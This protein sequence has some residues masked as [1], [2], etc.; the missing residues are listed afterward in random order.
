MRQSIVASLASSL[1]L[2]LSACAADPEAM[3]PEPEPMPD[4]P[5]APD[6]P[7]V[8]APTPAVGLAVASPQARVIRGNVTSID[9]NVMRSG[10]ATGVI[11]VSVEGLPTG[12]TAAGVTIA[13][14]MTTGSL[15]LSGDMSLALG[16]YAT[17]TVR[18]K[19]GA[20]EATQPLE[21]HLTDPS[22]ALDLTLGAG[23]MFS[24]NYA[25]KHD[26]I[27]RRVAM[28]PDGRILVAGEDQTGK[29]IFIARYL[30]DGAR[31]D[32]F[33]I[34][35]M[36]SVGD[37]VNAPTTLAL[38]PTA[39]GRILLVAKWNGATRVMAFTA[40]GATDTTYGTSGVLDLSKVGIGSFLASTAVIQADGTVLLA[41]MGVGTFD[42]VRVTPAGA[43]DVAFDGDGKATPTFGS[44]TS[45][46]LAL[47]T[48]P[49]GEVVIA[50]AHNNT[51]YNSYA[52]A[53]LTADGA[54]DTTFSDDGKWVL[55]L[56]SAS[57]FQRVTMMPDGR[58]ALAGFYGANPQIAMLT[59]GGLLDVGFG[60]NGR[61]TANGGVRALVPVEGGVIAVD[62]ANGSIVLEKR[63]L[64]G[65]LDA[66]FG[67]D[68]VVTKEYLGG[69]ADAAVDGQGRLVVATYLTSGLDLGDVGLARF[70]N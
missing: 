13:D 67:N 69:A 9:V 29:T 15:E 36:R 25:D 59:P 18:A 65:A 42:V 49:T 38:A 22:G 60:Q 8:D 4:A 23:G 56:G 41:A 1:A 70:W 21:L 54:M 19:A 64:D 40:T 2:A 47:A 48:T 63:R 45:F 61:V 32:S 10:G 44:G 3:L 11:T 58:I 55:D 6:V 34:G 24:D 35:G 62:N 37:G 7:D 51:M 68:G 27:V 14:G 50:G 26:E 20:L 5:L 46:P 39:S 17:V 33:G 31:D 30:P 28:Q 57:S 53:R 66:S 52:V 16:T 43:L 12:V